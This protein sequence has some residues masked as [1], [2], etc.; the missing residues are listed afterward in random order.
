[1][2]SATTY[3]QTLCQANE[4]RLRRQG[5]LWPGVHLNF[6]GTQDFLDIRARRREHGGAWA[7]LQDALADFP[8]NALISNELLLSQPP[9]QLRQLIESLAPA[10]VSVVI[11]ARDLARVLPSHWQ[12]YVRS[13]GTTSWTDYATAVLLGPGGSEDAAARRFWRQHNLP[14][15]IAQCAE[16]V[17]PDRV[18]LVTIP[19]SGSDPTLTGQRFLEAMGVSAKDFRQPTYRKS[20]LGAHSVE[21]ARR[22][23]AQVEH[24]SRVDRRAALRRALYSRLLENR[25]DR[26]P[27][28]GLSPEQWDAISEY[29]GR[30]VDELRGVDVRLVG[31]L[32]DL[33]PTERPAAA[34][35]DPGESSA[36]DLLAAA[37]HGLVGLAA[38]YIVATKDL[39]AAKQRQGGGRVRRARPLLKSERLRRRVLAVPG[40]RRVKRLRAALRRRIR[41]AARPEP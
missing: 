12:T 15:I 39:D 14:R 18:T 38:K 16:V 28:F 37:E 31:E 7:K 25:S 26:E 8:D 32:D 29:A 21:L 17:S 5:L 22:L 23:N 35:F 2:K 1:M 34:A 36:E 13:G 6:I 27:R 33:I 11:T 19:P 41:R 3:L 20:S 24:W 9:R 10:E 4:R 30:M 40:A